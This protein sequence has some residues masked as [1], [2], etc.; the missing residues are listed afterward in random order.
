MYWEQAVGRTQV[1]TMHAEVGACISYARMVRSHMGRR[2]RATNSLARIHC[3]SNER[4]CEGIYV[5]VTIEFGAAPMWALPQ[6]VSSGIRR[7]QCWRPHCPLAALNPWPAQWR[8]CSGPRTIL[9]K[10]MGA[11]CMC[12]WQQQRQR[13]LDRTVHSHPL[14]FSVPPA[15]LPTLKD[16][17]ATQKQLQ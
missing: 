15:L 14:Y 12:M 5:K 8:A 7:E 1:Q 9:S 4:G 16:K 10:P 2:D 6:H 13:W 17:N 11:A 3:N